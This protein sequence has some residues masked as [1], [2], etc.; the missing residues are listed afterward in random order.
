MPSL[1][2]GA[3]Q[4]R[5]SAGSGLSAPPE[6]LLDQE[7]PYGSRRIVVEYDGA[8]TAAY[9][10]DSAGPIAAT[11]IAN[12][13][14]APATVDLGMLSSGQAPQMPAGHTKHPQG[15]PPLD[16]AGLSA[17]WL[18][19]GDGV[20]V[21][22]YGEPI[23]VIPGW[24]DMAT[25]MPGYAADIIGQ[26]P[27]GWSLDL[28]LEGLAPR[29]DA[30]RRFW[31]WRNDPDTWASYRQAV[32]GHLL[33]RLG[34]GG[35]YWDVSGGRAPMV[36]VSERPPTP[37]RPYAVLATVGMSAQRMPA[38]EQAGESAAGRARIELALAT[39]MPSAEAARIFLWLAQ[40]PWR[41]VTWLGTGHGVPWYHEPATFP[42][43]GPSG[44]NAAVLLLDEPGALLGPDVP[45][46][47]GFTVSGAPVRWLW[48]VP[49]SERERLLAADRG[50]G[51]LVTQLA[52]QRRSWVTSG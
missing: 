48:V 49:I 23:A 25:G 14:A 13:S 44:E 42:L 39:T 10:H 29:I 15:R 46:L 19:E 1:R 11:W 50:S 4:A 20:A 35:K 3:G 24:S 30:A 16:A 28:A 2:R 18:E 47:G 37:Q 41:E 38:I 36:G 45:P 21:L 9:V 32:F 40:Y 22:E 52:A 43:R 5:I 31:E 34:P 17:L 33:G 12:H 7:S 51:R 8:T 26:T 6:V 27:F